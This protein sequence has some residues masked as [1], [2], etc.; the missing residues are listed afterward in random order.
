MALRMLLNK[1]VVHPVRHRG[2]FVGAE[3]EV[4]GTL[5]RIVAVWVPDEMLDLQSVSIDQSARLYSAHTAPAR[6]PRRPHPP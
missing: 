4:T 3:M 1:V 6:P 5:G 2:K